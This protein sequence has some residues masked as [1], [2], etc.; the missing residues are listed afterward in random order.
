[1]SSGSTFKNAGMPHWLD[2][3]FYSPIMAF[4]EA[5]GWLDAPAIPAEGGPQKNPL[6]VPTASEGIPVPELLGTSL[7]AGNFLWYCCRRSK[8]IRKE[9]SSGGGGKGG[10]GGGGS[11][12]QTVGYKY[13]LTWALGICRGP[14][15][16]LLAVW[17]DDKLVWSGDLDRATY[18][19]EATITLDGMGPMTFY[20][21][22]NT[23][24]PNSIIGEKV[25]DNVPYR[26][27]C[28]AFFNDCY[29]GRRN[30]AP[31]MKFLVQKTPE[32]A[33]NAN[34]LI[35][36][37][38]D[39]NPAHAL[40]HIL[41]DA[42]L[43]EGLIDDTA[44]S[45]AAETLH[46]EG[47]GISLLMNRPRPASDYVENILSHIDAAI[48]WRAA[49]KL[50]LRLLRDDVAYENIHEVREADMLE[51]PDLSRRQLSETSNVVK[52]AFNKREGDKFVDG[53]VGV[54]DM[55][56]ARAQG[57]EV[58][59]TVK[60]PL[61]TTKETAGWA[62]KRILRAAAYP[63]AQLKLKLNRK[64]FRLEPGD[65][66]KLYYDPFGIEGT[67]YR[68]NRVQEENLNSEALIVSATEDPY[69]LG[70]TA[71]WTPGAGFAED[72]EDILQRFSDPVVIEPPYILDERPGVIIPLAGR[73]VG[74]ETGYNLYLSIDGG[75]SYIMAG[76]SDRFAV[77]GSLLSPGYSAAT[78]QV[79]DTVGFS[80]EI[81]HDAD[82][83]ET[84]T[85]TEMLAW[86]N[87]A[88]LI[89]ADGS[90]QELVSFQT[91]TP[92]GDNQ[93]K[94]EN[95]QRGLFDTERASFAAGDRFFWLNQL[96]ATLLQRLEVNEGV[97]LKIKL[98]PYT[99]AIM[100]DLSAA[101]A[102]DYTVTDRSEMP[103]WP[104]NYR[105]TSRFLPDS[106]D[107]PGP[108]VGFPIIVEWR[109][110]YKKRGAGYGNPLAVSDDA[111]P[112]LA[113]EFEIQV[114]HLYWDSDHWYIPL[115]SSF[116]YTPGALAFEYTQSMFAADE[117][118]LVDNW[119]GGW[120]G[121]DRVELR[122]RY[123]VK[124]YQS[125][126]L[127]LPLTNRLLNSWLFDV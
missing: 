81:A 106:N 126:G 124:L 50:A 97:N 93:Y 22:T 80:V 31:G 52:V 96:D 64:H 35:G 47:L 78:R 45:D 112:P 123:V 95:V 29:L 107:P 111:P 15:D 99:D 82:D 110:R 55:A 8:P 116:T 67:V 69:Y 114:N 46:A 24:S 41:V 70:Q 72:V 79:D 48:I 19:D 100:D 53:M 37:D 66:F 98:V 74:I 3:V 101:A 9:V 94:L 16:K 113:P 34:H 60:M 12:T 4:A 2:Y 13:F 32:A 28:W 122:L 68:V 33:F 76:T 109:Q 85:R 75:N 57:C 88:A 40:R 38:G 25:T 62:A 65:V 118:W 59:K 102:I 104:V 61:F 120:P 83:I 1:M 108:A 92:L 105:P 117:Q 58:E 119:P 125:S 115:T 44:F 51:E 90:T 91:V 84:I 87:L 23:Q 121:T 73:E 49:G 14:V 27:L 43:D 127:W 18:G 56:N 17:M 77:Q 42:G 21:G 7:I 10:G 6:D 30:R 20:F 63:L 36:T 5:Q 86:G 39:Y 89:S 103:L 71:D 26:N 11:S 54:R